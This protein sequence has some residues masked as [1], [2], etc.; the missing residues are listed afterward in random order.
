MGSVDDCKCSLWSFISFH[1]VVDG[2]A[3]E[4][5]PPSHFDTSRRGSICFQLHLHK[6]AFT[7][8]SLHSSRFEVN[9]PVEH[10]HMK[11]ESI[12]RYAFRFL[13]FWSRWQ[14]GNN[15][16]M[17]QTKF[18]EN[19]SKAGEN[20][21]TIKIWCVQLNA[22]GSTT[23]RIDDDCWGWDRTKVIVFKIRTFVLTSFVI[24]FLTFLELFWMRSANLCAN[25][26]SLWRKSFK[27]FIW[28]HSWD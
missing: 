9:K 17:N 4:T 22:Y 11:T 8:T 24:D 12:V 7:T 14:K 23:W 16:S 27:A 13:C 18:I 5:N 6:S 2:R 10:W 21:E 1:F 20:W 19:F 15:S 26:K 3:D 25:C 28:L